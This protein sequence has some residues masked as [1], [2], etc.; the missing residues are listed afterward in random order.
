MSKINSGLGIGLSSLI[1][2]KKINIENNGQTAGNS[3]EIVLD[4]EIDKISPNPYQPRKKFDHAALEELAESIKEQGI[5]QPLVASKLSDGSYEL[6]AGERR[7]KASKIA[8]LR[9]VPVIIKNFSSQKKMEAAFV[10]NAQRENLNAIEEAKF[11][12][13]LKQEFDLT[14]E[15]IAQSVGKSK[16]TISNA[17]R[18]LNLPAEVQRRIIEGKI[19]KS[20]ALEILKLDGIEKQILLA[21]KI[22]EEGLSGK[23][24]AEII[25]N[26]DKIS[27][28]GADIPTNPK[29]E[30]LASTEK[31]LQEKLG[32]KVKIS[33]SLNRGKIAIDFFGEE[34]LT[35][36]ARSI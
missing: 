22:D 2:N 36:I 11:Y 32:T 20:L 5:L 21:K 16:E 18:V 15:E 1:P 33:G 7:L 34:E 31:E 9:K 26:Q 28:K 30:K 12:E 3:R 19:S 4:V 17:L 27:V 14:L 8:G 23:E 29:N 25:K 13:N 10:E 6:I 35:R 24:I